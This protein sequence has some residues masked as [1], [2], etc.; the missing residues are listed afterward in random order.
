VSRT[1]TVHAEIEDN[2]LF[3][4]LFVTHSEERPELAPG[5]IN[6][7]FING[8]NIYGELYTDDQLNLMGTYP[9]FWGHVWTGASSVNY[10]SGADSRCFRDG[11]TFN[12]P[13]VIAFWSNHVER[14][15]SNALSVG[16]LSLTGNWAIAFSATGTNGAGRVTCRRWST[17]TWSATTTVSLASVS[18]IYVTGYVT[19]VGGTVDGVLNLATSNVIYIASNLVYQSASAPNRTPWTSGFTSNN[20]DAVVLASRSNVTVMG[21]R[22]IEIHAGIVVPGDGPSFTTAERYRVMM[23]SRPTIFLYGGLYQYRRGIVGRMPNR[24]FL[25]SYKFDPNLRRLAPSLHEYGP[26]TFNQWRE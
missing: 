10:D 24:G 14:V 15:R 20:D 5:D 1:V 13:P 9:W 25:K 4:H 6:L 19:N 8:D 18:N 23:P 11:I 16:G 12:A 22:D 7:W 21:T 26:Y 3:K 17:N 2:W